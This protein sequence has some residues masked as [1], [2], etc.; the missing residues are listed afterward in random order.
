MVMNIF[1]LMCKFS[2]KMGPHSNIRRLFVVP[3]ICLVNYVFISHHV[4]QL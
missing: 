2:N 4:L 3:Y 1:V